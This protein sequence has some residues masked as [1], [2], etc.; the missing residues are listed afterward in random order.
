MNIW[1]VRGGVWRQTVFHIYVWRGT[2]KKV[3]FAA[4]L[5]TR[6]T[7]VLIYLFCGQVFFARFFCLFSFGVFF[8]HARRLTERQGAWANMLS[9]C[10]GMIRTRLVLN[11]ESNRELNA[12][13]EWLVPKRP[14][15][16]PL[17][18]NRPLQNCSLQRRW[19]A[20]LLVVWLDIGFWSP[21]RVN[22]Q[23]GLV[24]PKKDRKRRNKTSQREHQNARK[25]ENTPKK[26][27]K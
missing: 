10:P 20:T 26:T 4:A 12:R 25:G 18:E 16:D 1:T 22:A 27:R 15:F 11:S 2:I 7:A 23:R 14:A 9:F 21:E 8:H 6:Y 24:R 17:T 13:R 3:S 5:C 19:W